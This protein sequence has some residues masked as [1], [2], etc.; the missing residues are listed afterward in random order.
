MFCL[1]I[2]SESIHDFHISTHT[3]QIEQWIQTESL[4]SLISDDILHL[5]KLKIIHM[6][7][8]ICSFTLS[9]YFC[10]DLLYEMIKMLQSRVYVNVSICFI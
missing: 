6:M 8:L 10:I 4:A 7:I 9:E 3:T 1:W 2:K 5:G